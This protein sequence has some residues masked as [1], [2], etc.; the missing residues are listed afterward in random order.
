MYKFNRMHALV[1]W[2]AADE[3]V[4]FFVRGFFLIIP[5]SKVSELCTSKAQV[6]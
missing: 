2:C 1:A 4:S 6:L 3:G 5:D